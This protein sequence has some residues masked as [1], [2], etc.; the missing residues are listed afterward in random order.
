MRL[1]GCIRGGSLAVFDAA[2]WLYSMRL[3]GCIRCGAKAKLLT[4]GMREWER[5]A[6][7]VRHDRDLNAAINLK[8]YAD[9]SAASACGEFNAYYAGPAETDPGKQPLRSRNQT[10]NRQKYRFIKVFEN[11]AVSLVL[12][13]NCYL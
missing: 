11:G 12:F 4:L 10:A 5:E 9:S 7:G 8:K 1:A 2:R 13:N 6:C 3:A